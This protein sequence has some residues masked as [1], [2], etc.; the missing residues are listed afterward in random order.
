M[1]G[2]RAVDFLVDWE[3]WCDGSGIGTA[4]L[5]S[6]LLMISQF[7]P[8]AHCTHLPFS[9]P[10]PSRLN[11]PPNNETRIPQPHPYAE[12]PVAGPPVCTEILALR[13][14]E[15]FLSVPHHPPA[16]FLGLEYESWRVFVAS[17]GGN[18]GG[19]SGVAWLADCA[20]F[21]CEVLES[22]GCERCLCLHTSCVLSRAKVRW[23]RTRGNRVESGNEEEQH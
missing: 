12:T 11:L 22:E 4:I 15:H 21:R 17:E 19:K 7:N 20:G 9:S 2:A 13:S 16:S 8:C 1:G 14:M 23:V 10:S 6:Y 5:L 18:W 3:Y